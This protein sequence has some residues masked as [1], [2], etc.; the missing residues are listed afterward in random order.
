MMTPYTSFIAVL[1]TVRNPGAEGTD[2]DQPLPLP[3]SVSNLAVGYRSGS[4]PG[5]MLLLAG[6]VFILFMPFLYKKICLLLQNR[7]RIS[8]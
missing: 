1:D 3:L 6:L 2:V 8:L 7:K 4:E 5:E